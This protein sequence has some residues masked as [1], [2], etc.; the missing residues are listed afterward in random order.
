[1]QAE[2]DLLFATAR[3]RMTAEIEDRIRA[4]VQQEV[5]WI[6][7]IRLALQHETIALLYWNLQRICPQSVP[8]GILEALAARYKAQETETQNRTEELVRILGALK[9]QGILALAYKGPI[10]AQRLYGNLSL[11]EFSEFSDLDIMIRECDLLKARDVILSQGYRLSFL[12]PSEV[13]EYA[14]TNRELHFCRERNGE[15][16]LELHWRFMVRSARVKGDPERFL[17]RFETVSLAGTMVRSLPLEVYFLI[18]SLHATKH[19]WRKVK[20]ICDI[21]EILGSP[22]LDWEYVAREAE[23]LGLRRMLAVAVLLAEDPL[24]VVAPAALMRRLK[25]DRM[26]QVLAAECRQGLLQEPDENWRQEAEYNFLFQIR[27]RLRDRASMFLCDRL[28][29]K[30]TPDERDRRFATMPE[31][32]S[33]LYYFVRPV[34]MAW[35]KM[36]EESERKFVS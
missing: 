34:R 33:A 29:P 18:L 17:E 8:A 15:R 36:T 35:E 14:R 28:L 22:D 21:A 1:M 23:D 13:S 9:N 25:V 27:E 6:Y 26:A 4:A 3:I 11:R 2:A 30:I 24:Q 12:K 10:L 7:L 16:M 31:C 19:K 32:L 5:D 20:L